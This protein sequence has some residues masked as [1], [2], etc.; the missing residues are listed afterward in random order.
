MNLAATCI[1]QNVTLI[2]RLRLDAQLFEFP[3]YAEKKLGRKPVKG[4]R[5][6]LK[7][8][9]AESE[10]LWQTGWVNWYG[11]EKRRLNI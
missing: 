2:F 11:G 6:Y 8:L 3:V 7:K 5:I 1:K 10:S 9:L 4:K